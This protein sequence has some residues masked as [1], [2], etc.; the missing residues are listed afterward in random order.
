[1]AQMQIHMPRE[2]APADLER[3]KQS[4]RER[5][6]QIMRAGKWP[7]LWR[8]AGRFAN[9]SIFDVDSIDELHTLICSLPM[10]PYMDITITPLAAHPSAL[11]PSASGG[12]DNGRKESHN[13]VGSQP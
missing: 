9:V 5:A 1:M 12:V 4:E 10:F 2:L 11:S 8:V 6:Q 13:D 7:H 3:L